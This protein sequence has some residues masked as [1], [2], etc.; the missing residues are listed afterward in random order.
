MS[1]Q[2]RR[3]RSQRQAGAAKALRTEATLPRTK[4]A[5]RQPR[6]TRRPL[7]LCCAA[8]VA[9]ASRAVPVGSGACSTLHPRLP[10]HR[11]RT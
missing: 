9:V 6:A 10:R 1:R 5:A 11:G 8:T 4:M 3:D 7:P 2:L